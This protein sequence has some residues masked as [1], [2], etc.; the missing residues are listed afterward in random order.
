[1]NALGLVF[2]N[3]HDNNVPELTQERTMGS[4]PFL[5]RYRLIDFALSN[6]VNSGV[7]KVGLI[8]KSTIDMALKKKKMRAMRK[9]GVVCFFRVYEN[10]SSPFFRFTGENQRRGSGKSR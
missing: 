5:G 3:I 9:K 7:A 1:M 2:S 6:L 10:I 8:T 4:I